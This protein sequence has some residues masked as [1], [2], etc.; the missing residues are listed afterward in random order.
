MY[1]ITVLKFAIHLPSPS[2]IIVNHHATAS[3]GHANNTNSKH[4]EHTYRCHTPS[5]QKHASANNNT[6][7]NSFF[8]IILK[9][10]GWLTYDFYFIFS[11]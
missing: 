3:T 1:L 4:P 11:P 10:A 8:L 2:M 6:S 7:S 5:K 9:Y